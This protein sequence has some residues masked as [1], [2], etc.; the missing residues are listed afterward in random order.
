MLVSSNN[1]LSKQQGALFKCAW[2]HAMKGIW[3]HVQQLGKINMPWNEVL[4]S[5]W[6]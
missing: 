5:F 6:L 3:M 4:D 2:M 1:V